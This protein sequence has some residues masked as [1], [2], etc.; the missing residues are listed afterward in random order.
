MEFRQ[1]KPRTK[2]TLLQKFPTILILIYK[3]ASKHYKSTND[4]KKV[5]SGPAS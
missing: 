4:L 5:K 2:L 3:N 1:R